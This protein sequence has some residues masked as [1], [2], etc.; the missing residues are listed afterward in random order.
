MI[1]EDHHYRQLLDSLVEHDPDDP[2]FGDPANWPDW[3][4]DDFAELGMPRGRD[5]SF[6]A[7]EEEDIKALL[8]LEER[9]SYEQ[10]C[11]MHFSPEARP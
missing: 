10:G 9:V 4:D 6:F 8:D 7:P 5:E 1:R 2:C 11:C 3:T